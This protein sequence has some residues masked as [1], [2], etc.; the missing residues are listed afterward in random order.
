MKIILSLLAS[1]LYTDLLFIYAF[2][3]ICGTKYS[4]KTTIIG[5]ILLWISDCLLKVFP[6]YIWGIEIMGLLNVFMLITGILYMMI[7]FGSSMIKRLFVF[8]IYTFAVQGIMDLTGMN[9]AGML[10]GNYAYLNKESNFTI[11]MI[12]CSTIMI[13]LGTLVFVWIWKNFERKDQKTFKLQW[14][15]MA[16]PLSQYALIHWKALV[17]MK[18]ATAFPK[19]VGIGLIL[20]ILADI[21]MFFLFEKVNRRKEAELELEHLKYQ[22]EVEKIRYEILKSKQLEA[23]KLQHDLKNCILVLKQM[24]K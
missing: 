22:Q 10:I 13:T 20:A 11:V 3:S 7:F 4:P 18:K 23:Q 15:C 19:V 16:L 9:I 1:Y 8:F 2:G 12:I 5:T 24:D 17:Y 14:L 21:Y 6:Q